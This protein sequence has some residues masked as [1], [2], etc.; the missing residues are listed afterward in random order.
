MMSFVLGGGCF[1]CLDSAYVN[2]KG[3]TA[4]DVGY[5][6]GALANPSYERVCDGNTGHA[7]VV[8]V[9][10]DEVHIPGSIILDMFFTMHDPTQLN[11]Q[12][13]D[14]GTQYRTCMFYEDDDQRELFEAARDRAKEYWGDGIVTEIV[15]IEEFWMGEDYHQDYFAKNP[16]NGYCQAVVAPKVAKVRAGFTQYLLG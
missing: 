1:W 7:E 3:V 9:T 16:G 15:P 10:F 2:F 4:V 12:G 6:G 14:V 13:N 5:M 11:R 8:R